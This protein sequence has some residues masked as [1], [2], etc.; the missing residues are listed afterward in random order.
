MILLEGEN[1]L[2]DALQA[3]Q[4]EGSRA[5]VAQ[6]FKTQGN[7]AVQELKWVD[8]KEFYTKA[9]TVIN[10]KEDKWEKPEDPKEEAALLVKLTEASHINR[11]L[12]NLELGMSDLDELVGSLLM[13]CLRRK[14]PRLQS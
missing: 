12:C 8:A 9:I 10:A 6:T 13:S 2:L 5:E 3:L 4:N 14:L 11:A 1:V 7:E